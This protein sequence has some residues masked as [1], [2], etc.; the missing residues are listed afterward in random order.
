MRS[1]TYLV[2]AILAALLALYRFD[3]VEPDHF[4]AGLWAGVAMFNGFAAVFAL[5]KS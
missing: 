1:F 3:G 2:I 5:V 4:K